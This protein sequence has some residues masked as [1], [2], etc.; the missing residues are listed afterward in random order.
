MNYRYGIISTATIVPRFIQAVQASKDSVIAIASRSLAKAQKIADTYHIPKAYGSYQTLYEDKEVDIVYIATPNHTHFEAAMHALQH[1]KHVIVEKPF[2]LTAKEAFTMFC[3]AKEQGCFIME[4]QKS[5]FLPATIRLKELLKQQVLGECKQISMMSSFP[6]A[7]PLQ[8]WMYGKSGGVLYGSAT[9]TI[10]YL[11]YLFDDP[12]LSAQAAVDS[13]ERGAIIDAGIHLVLNEHLLADSRITMKVKNDN[14][15]MFYCDKGWIR[16]EHFWKARSLILH[17][18]E[19]EETVLSFPVDFE[20]IYEVNHI[21]ECLKQNLLVSPI[22]SAERTILCTQIVEELV[23]EAD[24][25][26]A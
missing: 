7:Y 26:A 18:Y 13:A 16:V 8:H 22:M 9:Y 4:A 1:H 10:E 15:A 25:D 17:P 20:M 21:H 24:D 14:A 12:T 3:F 23:H 6:D 19:G 11:M 2:T 5:V